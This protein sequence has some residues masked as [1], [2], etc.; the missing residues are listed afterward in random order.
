[1]LEDNILAT[2]FPDEPLFPKNIY[3]IQGNP[4]RHLFMIA[5]VAMTKES[6]PITILE[7]GSWAGS[8]ALTWA[9][10]IDS[11]IPEKGRILC[12]DSWDHYISK[13]D[14]KRGKVYSAMEKTCK[15]AYSIFLHNISTYGGGARIDHF[16]GP[17][18]SVL[19]YL[20]DNFFDIVY[21]D[22]SHYY[23]SVLFDI[24]QAC[25]LVKNGGIICGDD[26][27]LQAD[28]IDIDFARRNG[29]IDYI[30]DPKTAQHFHPGVTMAVNDTLGNVSNYF[31]Y[32]MVRKCNTNFEKINFNNMEVFI[33]YHFDESTKADLKSFCQHL[34]RMG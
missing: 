7:V 5:T 30:E 27:E 12:V 16:R 25:R 2:L 18:Q 11:I 29:N 26:L 6:S 28:Q 31:G 4:R 19:P 32:W 15:L 1:M 23:D 17:S 13:E 33:P 10:A 34:G 14:I 20:S 24:K 9:Q 22:G 8:S 3:G 21:L